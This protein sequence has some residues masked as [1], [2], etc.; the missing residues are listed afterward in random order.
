M[1][2]N[3]LRLFGIA[4]EDSV[5]GCW[6]ALLL[7]YGELKITNNDQ[8]CIFLQEIQI[9]KLHKHEHLETSG[10]GKYMEA[11]LN[12]NADHM[13]NNLLSIDGLLYE[14]MNLTI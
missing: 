9:R 8:S 12:V 1:I 11:Y 6:L 3:D 7:M 10:L 14:Y 5:R 2:S 4:S 13:M